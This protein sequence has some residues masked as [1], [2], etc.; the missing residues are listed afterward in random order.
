MCLV[1]PLLPPLALHG[2]VHRFLE[3]FAPFSQGSEEFK[4]AEH[5]K[6]GDKTLMFD[7]H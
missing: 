3:T 1:L 6:K 5:H 4:F 2:A 7:N